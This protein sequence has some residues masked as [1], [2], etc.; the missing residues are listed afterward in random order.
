MVAAAE[1]V[2]QKKSR[3][4]EVRS[5]KEHAGKKRQV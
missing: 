1:A 3:V 5:A 4:K 2:Q